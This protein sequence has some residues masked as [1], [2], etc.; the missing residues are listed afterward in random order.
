[1]HCPFLHCAFNTNNLKT[2][3]SHRSGKHKNTKEIRTCLTVHSENETCAIETHAIDQPLDNLVEAET[4]QRG[5]SQDSTENGREEY[6]EHK[7]VSLFLCMQ[8]VLHVSKSALQKFLKNLMTFYTFLNSIPFKI[9]K[10][11]SLSL[12]LK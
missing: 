11:Y 6:V 5:L 2:F 10:R 8:T 1:M 9:S 3:T 7:I 12:I 4:S